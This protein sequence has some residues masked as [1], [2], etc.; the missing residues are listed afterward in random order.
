MD[1][2]EPWG[3]SPH[4]GDMHASPGE[5]VGDLADMAPNSSSGL[6]WEALIKSG[7]KPNDGGR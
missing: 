1:D 2:T 4:E 3:R 5:W 6:R 7:G